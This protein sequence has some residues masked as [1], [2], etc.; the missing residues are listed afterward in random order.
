MRKSRRAPLL[1][2]LRTSAG[3]IAAALLCPASAGAAPPA[4]QTYIVT[5][6]DS[7]RVEAPVTVRIE[8][9]KGPSARAT[10]DRRLLDG[11]TLDVTGNM[12]T[13][14]MRRSAGERGDTPTGGAEIALTTTRLR[15][16]VLLGAGGVSADRLKGADTRVSLRGSGSIDVGEVDADRL[17]AELL[18]AGGLSLAGKANAVKLRVSGAGRVDAVRLRTLRS[19]LTVQGSADVTASARE[20]A[21]IIASG[22]ASVTVADAGKCSVRSEGS[23]SV[24]CGDKRF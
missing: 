21:S 7:I 16:V 9:G 13:I 14:R 2:R 8:T 22:S 19:D 1:P 6:F 15:N 5:D 3:L 20:E 10:G 24:Q 18:G 17:S 11:L 12:L 4:R 23:A